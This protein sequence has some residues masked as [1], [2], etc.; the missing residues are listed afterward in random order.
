VDT[1]DLVSATDVEAAML[2]P[3]TTAER[4]Y[5]P[6]KLAQ[7]TSLLRSK[8][9]TIDA[10]V[11][12]W[13]LDP[14]PDTAVDPVLVSSMLAEVIKRT[15]VNPRGLWSTTETDGDY[16]YSET[17]PG[18]RAGADA[19]TPGDLALTAADLAKIDAPAGPRRSIR[20][21]TL[22]YTERPARSFR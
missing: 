10:R 2:R 19:G 15:M 5:L 20:T 18:Q 16:S 21:S 3:L 14:R 11:A 8:R 6:V 12:Q 22:P 7:V 9:R 4:Q 1:D 13:F 17:Y